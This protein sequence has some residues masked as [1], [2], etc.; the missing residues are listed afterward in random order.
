MLLFSWDDF[1]IFND[2]ELMV[3]DCYNFI[4]KNEDFRK[5]MVFLFI[6]LEFLLCFYDYLF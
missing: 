1:I 3:F 4:S 6:V 5:K 2:D